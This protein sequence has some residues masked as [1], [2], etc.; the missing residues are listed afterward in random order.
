MEKRRKIA[1][2][3]KQCFDHKKEKLKQTTR[4]EYT[5]LSDKVKKKQQI[6]LKNSM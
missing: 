4:N 3:S 6:I 5:E 2:T 1:R